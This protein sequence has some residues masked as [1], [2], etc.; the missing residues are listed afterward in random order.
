M[1]ATTIVSRFEGNGASSLHDL[2]SAL[3]TDLAIDLGTSNTRVYVTRQGV[4][5]NE[6]SVIAWDTRSSQIIAVGQAAKAMIG[7]APHTVKVI[8][9]IW[10]GVVASFDAAQQMLWLFLRRAIARWKPL[11]PRVLMCVPGDITAVER[12]AFDELAERAGARSVELIEKPL[13]AAAAM[14]LTRQTVRAALILDVGGGMTSATV[15][16]R[17]GL[18]HSSTLRVGGEAVD[19]ALIRYFQREHGLELG[20]NLAEEIKLKLSSTEPSDGI[21]MIDV[22]GRRLTTRLPEMVT[23]ASDEIQAAIEPVIGKI[24]CYV[25]GVLEQLP[26]EVSA[27]VYRSGIALAGGASQLAFLSESLSQEFGIESRIVSDPS[28]AIVRGA[29]RLFEQAHGLIGLGAYGESLLRALGSDAGSI[30][31]SSSVASSSN[32]EGEVAP[33]DITPRSRR[34]PL[35]RLVNPVSNDDQTVEKGFTQDSLEDEQPRSVVVRAGR[36]IA[37]FGRRKRL[38]I[39][40]GSNGN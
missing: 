40:S 3:T 37:L 13:A 2:R 36:K 14:D 21:V 29:G 38:Q 25:R 34:R 22:I 27:D 8:R 9:P 23:V 18:I 12:R 5:L 10:E 31:D 20:E 6:P 19:Q 16:S 11:K 35:L 4:A 39:G 7:R 24:L 15:Y 17:D 1:K 32:Q 33:E 30:Q 28:L 26:A